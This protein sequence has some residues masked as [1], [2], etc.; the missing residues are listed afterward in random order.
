M[1]DVGGISGDLLRSFIERVERL[2][3]EKR[4]IQTD[5]KE[6]FSEAKGSGFD[7]GIIKLLI[8]ERRM[9]QATRDEQ[10]TL[11]SLYR[12][13]LAGWDN[14]T[15]LGTAAAI[16]EARTCGHMDG[17]NDCYDNAD[18]WPSGTPGHGDYALGWEDGH[19]QRVDR[20][21]GLEAPT[22]KRRRARIDA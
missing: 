5:I 16:S 20:E 8:K 1:P 14:S 13:A 18:R 10:E 15:P 22:P 12:D 19:S 21:A 17:L 9:D 4:T 3:E 6:V 2:E 7:V 11:L